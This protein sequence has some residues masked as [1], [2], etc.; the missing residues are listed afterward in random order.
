MN[1]KKGL[2]VGS[3]EGKKALDEFQRLRPIRLELRG[4]ECT[5]RC[6]QSLSL[7]NTC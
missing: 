2:S 7:S 5:P 3:G 6:Y 4:G 1:I